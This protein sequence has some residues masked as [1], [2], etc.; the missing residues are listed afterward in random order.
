MTSGADLYRLMAALAALR[1]VA[2]RAESAAEYGHLQSLVELIVPRVGRVLDEHF[3]ATGNGRT[4]LFDDDEP[5]VH[6]ND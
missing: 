3:A 6:V 5:E 2:L 1:W 4:G